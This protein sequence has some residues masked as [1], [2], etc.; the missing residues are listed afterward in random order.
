[1]AN[2]KDEA[3]INIRFIVISMGM[4]MHKKASYE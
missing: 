2:T 1:M 3:M 4:P